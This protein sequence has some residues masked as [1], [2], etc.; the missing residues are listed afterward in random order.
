MPTDPEKRLED[1]THE[2]I[3]S[4]LRGQLDTRI[5]LNLVSNEET[6]LDFLYSE[7]K[8]GDKFP[9]QISSGPLLSLRYT[10]RLPHQ[11]IEAVQ[12]DKIE[13]VVHLPFVLSMYKDYSQLD[14]QRRYFSELFTYYNSLGIKYKMVFHCGHPAGEDFSVDA[15]EDMFVR[16]LESSVLT[17]SKDGKFTIENLAS[18][19]WSGWVTPM[20][21]FTRYFV[22]GK[23][24]A[25]KFGLCIDTEHLFASGHYVN[26][27]YDKV[28]ISYVDVVHLN[29]APRVVT[30]SSGVDLHSYTEIEA[31][32]QGRGGVFHDGVSDVDAY[33]RL[34][35]FLQWTK[36]KPR[37][38]ERHLMSIQAKDIEFCN[39]L[40]RS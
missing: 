39:R 18:P 12:E 19:D 27:L 28:D 9:V 30:I 3:K 1:W 20:S 2:Q 6:W 11:L 7:L 14:Y 15:A 5:G 8:P 22:S 34:S 24:D 32:I 37:I 31:S 21:L 16:N 23:L 33:R 26:A 38:L 13:L 10:S 29:S 40:I 35:D 4:F 17:M 36:D 25:D